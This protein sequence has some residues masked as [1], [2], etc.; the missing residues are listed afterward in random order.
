MKRQLDTIQFETRTEVSEVLNVIAKYVKEHPA[1]KDN[2][3]LRELYN[4]LDVMEMDW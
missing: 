3:T 4:L 1:E 2:K